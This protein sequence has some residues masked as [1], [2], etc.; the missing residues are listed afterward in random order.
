MFPAT[1]IFNTR[2]DDV[3]RFPAHG[4]SAAWI[5]SIGATVRFHADWGTNDNPAQAS[6]YY[7]VPINVV[8]G[9]AATTEWPLVSFDFAPSGAS[10][11]TGWPDE[12]DCAVASGSG[13]SLTRNCAAVP[14]AQRRFPF[15]LA[16]NARTEGGQCNDPNSC[17]DHHVLVVEQG[18]CRLWEGYFSYRIADNWYSLAT[19]AWDLKSL[20]LRPSGW[21]SGDAA[22]LPITPLLARAAEASTGEVKHPL[23]VTFRDGVLA[24]SFDWPARHGAGGAT[25]GGI[26]FGALLRLR[27]E[28]V[29]PASWTPQAKALATAMKRYGLYVA[30]IGSNFYVQGEPNAAWD[31]NTIS[32][33]QTL[34]MGQMEFVDLGAVTGDA[35]F[36]RDSMAADW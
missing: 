36:S 20:A 25:A 12:S 7:G 29:I 28:F 2:I 22:G 19:A 23:R 32:Q 34:T 5:D 18:A 10:T 26:P 13:F 33:L 6:T 21:T 4:S 24:N 8:D 1:A 11:E 16:P 3:V 27:A 15:P 31:A 35:R 9:T 14:T 17:G 30:D